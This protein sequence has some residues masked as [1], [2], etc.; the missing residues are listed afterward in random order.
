MKPEER[1]FSAI[2]GVDETLLERSE[3][4]GARPRVWMR[5]ARYL[6]TAACLVLAAGVWIWSASINGYLPGSGRDLPAEEAPDVAAPVPAEPPRLE[7]EGAFCLT[8]SLEDGGGL[9]MPS[10]SY[11]LDD[12]GYTSLRY[13]GG[14]YIRPLEEMPKDAPS[15]QV[16]IHHL[17]ECTLEEAVE[18]RR[19][20]NA[21]AYRTVTLLDENSSDLARPWPERAA[22]RCLLSSDGTA[23]YDRQA[24]DW[25]FDDGQGG[26]FVLSSHY[27]TEAAEGWGTRFYK[28]VCSFRPE[29]GV[30]PAWQ[31]DIESAI[32]RI[33]DAAFAGELAEDSHLLAE[34]GALY[35][36][37]LEPWGPAW[38][39]EASVAGYAYNINNRDG[40]FTAG[41]D[42][43][44][45]VGE[46]EPR[47]LL[48]MS[49]RYQDG[50]WLAELVGFRHEDGVIYYNTRDKQD[51]ASQ[52]LCP[53]LG[54]SRF[55]R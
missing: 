10:Y 37:D 9:E 34:N 3:R 41:V 11:Y 17:P 13:A 25:F 39:E 19:A 28:F 14:I 32:R 22:K 36:E 35:L 12:S 8:R 20:E 2:G 6:V 53:K 7:G 21:K 30:V 52:V 44:V 42:V 47:S 46:E 26:F 49:L 43:I 38:S 40:A 48:G 45:R 23:A 15:C 50:Q 5:A 31:S 55:T 4:M 24:E 29:T 54:A 16:G 33:A 18:I 27:F 1:L 51:F